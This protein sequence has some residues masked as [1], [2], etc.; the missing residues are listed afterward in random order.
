MEVNTVR[1][2]RF[3]NLDCILEGGFVYP[4]KKVMYTG[5]GINPGITIILEVL[6]LLKDL[7][8]AGIVGLKVVA[9][10]FPFI[11][12]GSKLFFELSSNMLGK[13]WSK[14]VY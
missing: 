8:V 13:S 9:P 12:K 2:L 3:T 10:E 11:L 4:S 5:Y 1:V 14:K 6:H 7:F